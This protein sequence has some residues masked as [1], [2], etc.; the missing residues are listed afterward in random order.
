MGCKPGWTVR[1]QRKAKHLKCIAQGC[2]V[3]QCC[4][5]PKDQSKYD[6]NVSEQKFSHLPQW[7]LAFFAVGAVFALASIVAVRVRRGRSVDNRQFLVVNQED[8]SR[9]VPK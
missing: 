9:L 5:P 6:A 1:L 8:T 4:D 3:L 2:L 7:T